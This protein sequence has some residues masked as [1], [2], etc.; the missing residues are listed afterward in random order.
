MNIFNLKT[1]VL[2]KPIKLGVGDTFNVLRPEIHDLYKPNSTI[3]GPVYRPLISNKKRV[4]MSREDERTRPYGVVVNLELRERL[5]RI[6]LNAYNLITRRGY[7]IY[8]IKEVK[9]MAKFQKKKVSWDGV[10]SSDV[11]SYKLYWAV[12]GGVDYDS[13]FAEVG[14]VTEVI[15]PDDV[16]SFPL[17]ATDVEIGV[18]AVSH[19]GNES[20]MSVFIAAFDFTAPPAPENLMVKDI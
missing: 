16:P 8:T 6:Q 19:R 14:N 4:E 2:S 11:A 13:D 18:S 15:L 9:G 12:G 10:D 20:D 3:L 1:F 17:V 5:S 7:F